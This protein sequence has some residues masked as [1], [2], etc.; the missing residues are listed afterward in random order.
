MV[1]YNKYDSYVLAFVNG[2]HD[3]D[4]H[5]FKVALTNS[6]PN[7]ATHTG[8]SNIT[9]LATSGGYT[10]GGATTTITTSSSGTNPATAKV[11]GTDPAVW[12]GS[13]AGFTF[14]YAVLYNDTPTTPVA[15]PLV[16][17]WDYGSSQLVALGETLTV[18]LDASAG[19]FTVT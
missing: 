1:A 7:V 14:R 18:D 4:A 11:V 17:Y 6:A 15:D 10:A 2:V 19:I 13:G 9:E 3:W 16:S 5:V 8:L 12:T